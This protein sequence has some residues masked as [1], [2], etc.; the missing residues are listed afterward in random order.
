MSPE[1]AVV[2]ILGFDPALKQVG[3]L[4]QVLYVPGKRHVRRLK[5]PGSL[6]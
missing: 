4:L 1:C 6:K 3:A 2:A 5:T